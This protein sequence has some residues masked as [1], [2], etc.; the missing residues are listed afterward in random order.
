MFLKSAR[1][2]ALALLFNGVAHTT[3]ALEYIVVVFLNIVMDQEAEDATT[4]IY[5][6]VFTSSTKFGELLLFRS[7]AD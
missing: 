2:S 7:S 5:M 4:N 3:I 1:P 6:N